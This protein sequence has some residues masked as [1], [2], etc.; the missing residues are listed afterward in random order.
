[1]KTSDKFA[2]YALFLTFAVLTAFAMGELSAI[3]LGLLGVFFTAAATAIIDGY[4]HYQ[5]KQRQQRH[6]DKMLLIRKARR[7]NSNNYALFNN[8]PL[9]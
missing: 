1:M 2:F 4:N 5:Q 3:A 7:I 6:K 8:G 9:Q